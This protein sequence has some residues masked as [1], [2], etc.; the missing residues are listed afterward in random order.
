VEKPQYMGA[1]LVGAQLIGEEPRFV[2]CHQQT[3]FS[4]LQ[5]EVSTAKATFSATPF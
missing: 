1:T 4:N 2:L 5:A 3:D